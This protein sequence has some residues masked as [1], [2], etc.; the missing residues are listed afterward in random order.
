MISISVSI[1]GQDRTVLLLTDMRFVF[2]TLFSRIVVVIIIMIDPVTNALLFEI[3]KQR[4]VQN[5]NVLDSAAHDK[6]Q[7]AP[8]SLRLLI[9][10]TLN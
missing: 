7:A 3:S 5:G 6:N 8:R 1:S 10:A 2:A 9:P 4:Y